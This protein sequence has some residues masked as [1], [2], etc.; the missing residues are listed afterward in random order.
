[1]KQNHLIIRANYY[2]YYYIYLYL[3]TPGSYEKWKH[4]YMKA[5]LSAADSVFTQ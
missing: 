1:M 5:V 3:F 4:P 2:K